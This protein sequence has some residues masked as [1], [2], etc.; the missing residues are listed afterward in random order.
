MW[1]KSVNKSG[2]ISKNLKVT[3]CGFKLEDQSYID[4]NRFKSP[5]RPLEVFSKKGVLRNFTKFTGKR[6]CQSL[7]FKKR[8]SSTG[9]FL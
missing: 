8:D 7:F 9:V 3:L 6:L 4:N 5:K 1:F 2:S